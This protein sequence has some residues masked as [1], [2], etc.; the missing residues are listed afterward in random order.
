MK[1]I[2]GLVISLILIGCGL[3]GKFVLRGTDSSAALVGAGVIYLIFDLIG[4]YRDKKL[5][6]LEKTLD[7]AEKELKDLEEPENESQ[8]PQTP[9]QKSV[10]DTTPDSVTPPIAISDEELEEMAG[11]TD[12][13]FE[14]ETF[15]PSV[16][17]LNDRNFYDFF[18]DYS[19]FVVCF[20]ESNNRPSDV[21]MSLVEEMASGEYAGRIKFALFDTR[22]KHCLTTPADMEIMAFPCL[23]FYKN[24]QEI[25]RQMGVA[26]RTAMKGWLDELLADAEHETDSYERRMSAGIMS[27][28]WTTQKK[29]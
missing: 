13:S 24:G 25:R 14:P 7:D 16:I 9:E 22:Q 28:Q 11:Q 17:H 29:S 6:E 10:V 23:V 8:Q 2:A 4:I 1:R 26:T 3:S 19:N 5:E 15:D 18:M 27:Y 12:P 20:C 21:M